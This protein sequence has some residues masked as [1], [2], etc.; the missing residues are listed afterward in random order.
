[1]CCTYVYKSQTF[2]IGK[3]MK[4]LIGVNTLTS[5]EQ[6]TYSNHVQFFHRLKMDH[7]DIRFGIMNPR[8][9]SV[10]RMRNTAAKFALENEFDYLMFIDDDVIVPMDCLNK[11]L[12]ANKDIIAGHTLI[13]GYPFENMFFRY[14]DEE[15][16]KL[17]YVKDDDYIRGVTIPVDAVGFS[18]C[19]IK[20]DLLKKVPPPF[21]VTGTYNTEDV[22]FCIKASKYV[23]DVTIS[24]DTSI[25]TAHL[26]GPE[27]IATWNKVQ[28]K[29][30]YEKVYPEL[31]VNAPSTGDRGEKYAEMVDSL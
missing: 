11:M 3:N 21:F 10:D 22:Y 18:C 2:Q 14:S 6:P 7:P 31:T 9:M 30:Y 24:V 8:R 19:L 28:Y 16:T 13:R 29:E 1:M 25:E 5:V 17:T 20:C 4:I 12:K 23:P 27:Y 15:K 26:L